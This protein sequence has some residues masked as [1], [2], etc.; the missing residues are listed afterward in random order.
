MATLQKNYRN[1]FVIGASAGGLEAIISMV[2]ALPDDLP[3][4]IFIVQHMP[5]Y[6]Q[7]NL[8]TILQHHTNLEVKRGEDG[9]VVRS[10]V[11]YMASADRHLIVEDNRVVVSKGPRENRFRPAVDTL[12]RSASV[13]YRERVVGI[14]LSGVLNDGTSGMWTIKRYGGT[15]IVQDPEEAIFPDMPSGVMQYTE[16]DHVLRADEIGKLM[17]SICR[18]RI[19]PTS[20]GAGLTDEK[21]LQI[22]IGI[23]K[24]DN[25]LMMGLLEHGGPSPLTCPECHGALTQFE[26]G[27]LVRY[28]CHTGHAHTGD[29]LLNSLRDNLEK[30]MWELMR[31]MEEARL[32]LERMADKIQEGLGDELAQ[33]YR[34]RALRFQRQAV[35]VQRMIITSDP[36]YSG[37]QLDATTKPAGE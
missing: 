36:S 35:D 4:A 8:G 15:A 37:T 14:V 2:K 19:V 12:F 28:R 22:E 32:L 34:E 31:G 11:I 6:A 33:Q 26:E 3:A 20:G 29:S 7:S 17:G 27:H 24:G 23:G 13:C 25:G 9:E 16:V 1:I 10:G 21:L 18:E 5:P 30:S